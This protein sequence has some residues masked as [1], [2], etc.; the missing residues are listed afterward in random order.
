MLSSVFPIEEDIDVVFVSSFGVVTC[1][2]LELRSK[3]SK[4]ELDG[5]LYFREVPPTVVAATA[6]MLLLLLLP[7]TW[8]RYSE[9][10]IIYESDIGSNLVFASVC[11]LYGG[12]NTIEVLFYPEDVIYADFLLKFGSVEKNFEDDILDYAAFL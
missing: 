5:V 3:G 2:L 9:G 10:K 6:G 11:F 1:L 12:G 7:S 4:S 8:D